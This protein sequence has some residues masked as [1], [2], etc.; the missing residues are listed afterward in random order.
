MAD[1]IALRERVV[2]GSGG[3]RD[4]RCDV[5]TPAGLSGT[6]P[7]LLLLHGGG[8]RMGEPAMLRGYAER[9][10]GF[11]FVCV[12]SEY[13]L[14]PESAWPAQIHDVRE[15][16]RWVVANAAE[17]QIDLKRLG[18]VGSSAGAHLALLA[19]GTHGLAEFGGGAGGDNPIGAVCAI[20]PPTVFFAGSDRAHGGVPA[21]ALMGEAES[22]AAS[23]AAGPL[24][25][26]APD[27]PPTLLLHGTADK[28]VPPSASMVMYEALVK[29]GVPAELHMYAEQP[30]GFAREPQFIAQVSAEIAHFMRRYL[31]RTAVQ[32]ETAAATA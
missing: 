6:A 12:A 11:G 7:G 2:F 14:T 13:R 21:R 5:Y 8:W 27:F 31:G 24:T 23:D 22:A 9:L 20:Y 3:G 29:A 26:V 16:L 19:A 15:A 32:H 17:L 1:A 28:V 25:Y 4:L 10:A 30:H 18:A